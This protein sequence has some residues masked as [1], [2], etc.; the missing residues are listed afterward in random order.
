MLQKMNRG[1]RAGR[2][3]DTELEAR[4]AFRTAFRMQTEAPGSVRDRERAG[5]DQAAL[6]LRQTE[7]EGLR[8]AVHP[9]AAA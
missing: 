1:S 4:F 3:P 2:M 8:V 7:T 9:G 5:F 6:R